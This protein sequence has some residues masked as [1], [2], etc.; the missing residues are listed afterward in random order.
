MLGQSSLLSSPTRSLK[1]HSY[2]PILI[3]LYFPK[4]QNALLGMNLPALLENNDRPTD[5]PST[6]RHTDQI[7][8]QRAVRAGHRE[9]THLIMFGVACHSGRAGRFIH[10]CLLVPTKPRDKPRQNIYIRWRLELFSACKKLR[11]PKPNIR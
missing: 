8:N 5:Q 4:Y 2:K 6:D 1:K 7:T 9:V 11:G 10:P 3:G